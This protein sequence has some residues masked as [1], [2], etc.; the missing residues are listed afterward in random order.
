MH[1]HTESV[2]LLCWALVPASR[3]VPGVCRWA[4]PLRAGPRRCGAGS[5]WRCSAGRAVLCPWETNVLLHWLKTEQKA[6]QF[7]F[8]DFG[9]MV[10][11]HLHRTAKKVL[12]LQLMCLLGVWNCNQVWSLLC[13][14]EVIYDFLLCYCR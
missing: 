2:S 9:S 7:V 5:S 1:R 3:A 6:N 14:I 12:H 13:I 11:V 10:W 4:Q 8:Q